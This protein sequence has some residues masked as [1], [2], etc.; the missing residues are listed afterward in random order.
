MRLRPL[1][2]LAVWIL[3]GVVSAQQYAPAAIIFHGHKGYSGGAAFSDGQNMLALI[4]R[5]GIWLYDGESFE[6]IKLLKIPENLAP[7]FKNIVAAAL[8]ADGTLAAG[9]SFY[10]AVLIWDV[11]SGRLLHALGGS[12]GRVSAAAFS[13]DGKTLAVLG[14]RKPIELWN[15]ETREL[16]K[17]LPSPDDSQALAFSPD[18]K[19]LASSGLESHTQLWNVDTGELIDTVGYKYGPNQL[20]FSPDGTTLVVGAHKEVRFY[21]LKND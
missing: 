4:G 10:G 14:H 3:A 5:E 9:G 18:G 1:L 17:T 21:A 15:V 7:P 12:T 16:I 13:M 6:T 11:E 19:T 20:A 2:Y 8:S